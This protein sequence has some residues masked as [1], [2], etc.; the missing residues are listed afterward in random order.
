L[1]Q[2][3]NGL[4]LIDQH[5]A[6]ERIRYEHYYEKLGEKAPIKGLLFPLEFEFRPTDSDVIVNNLEALKTLGLTLIKTG[7]S[8]ELT[9]MPAWL[10]DDDAYLFVE[11]IVNSLI[12]YGTVNLKDLRDNLSKSIA[13]KGAIKA[14]NPLNNN[15]VHYL[16]ENLRKTKNPYYCP[17]GRPVLIFFSLYEI[18]KMFKR[19][20]WK[21]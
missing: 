18:E 12:K 11:N 10:A 20:V 6:A 5:A 9:E 21:K 8:F 19:V 13:C 4:Y 2:N 7:S 15:E 3:E 14:N 17:H 1:F 16:I